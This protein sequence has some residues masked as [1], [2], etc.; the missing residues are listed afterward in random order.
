MQGIEPLLQ[1]LRMKMVEPFLKPGG[2]LVDLGCDEEMTLIYQQGGRMKKAYGLDIIAEP[3]K[4]KNVEII[5]ADLTKRLP[6]PDEMADVVTMLAVLEH[7]PK[8][9]RI[10]NEA[11]RIL[12]PGGLFLVTV[13]SPAS[14][15]I[16][17]L[18]AQIGLV[19]KEMV[20]QHETY[21]TPAL[22]RATA[23]KAGFGRIMVEKWELGMNTFMRAEK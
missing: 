4:E 10:V 2:V 16:L 8:P 6:L 21:F 15:P 18:F 3:K 7:I 22:L 1:W 23:Q 5:R 12:R 17:E 13:P 14:R 11:Y 19:R 20:D 9:Q